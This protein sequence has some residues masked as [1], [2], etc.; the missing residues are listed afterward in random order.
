[1]A[2]LKA[3]FKL[4]DGYSTTIDKINRK[5]YVVTEKIIKAS[6]GTDNFNKKLKSTGASASIANN[7]LKKLV[8]TFLSLA[9]VK[10]GMDIADEFTNTNA[11]LNLIND[12]LQTQ[13]ELQDKIFQ[14]AD[15]AK[16]AYGD[17]ANAVARLQLL[18]GDAFLSNDET[19]AFTELLQKAFKVSGTDASEQSAALLQLSQ[20][21]ASGRLQG[22]EFVSISENAP[23]ILEA[24]SRYTGKSRGE[25]KELS[26]DGAITADII[27]NSMFAMAD[28]INEKFETLPMTFGDIWNKI[29]NGG[30]KAFRPLMEA[31]SNIINSDGFNKMLNWIFTGIGITSSAINGL[32]NLIIGNW[33][34][35]EPILI[36]IGAFLLYQLIGYLTAA[37]P[38]L[39]THAAMWIMMNMPIIRVIAMIAGVIFILQQMGVTFEDIFGFVGGVVGIFTGHFYNSFVYMWNMVASFINFFG[40]VFNN[41]VASVQALFYD[42][43]VNVLGYIENMAKGIED[44]LNKIPGVE[45]NITSGI[46][47]LKNKLAAKSAN[48]KSEAGL[49][50]YV[51]SKEFMDYSQAYTKGSNIGKNVYGD[52]SGAISDLTDKLTGTG[53]TFDLSNFGTSSN[54]LT[55]EG[56]GKNKKL[57]VDMDD[58]DLKYLRDIAER[59]YVNK[60]STA[61]LAPNIQVTF[62][63]VYEEADAGKVAGRIKKILQEEI[64]IAAEGV[65]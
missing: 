59:E 18:A 43:A 55:V 3:M 11:R 4:F 41:P 61:T 20:A 26:S 22:D 27:K 1:M 21:M 29:K 65:Y 5:T 28:D 52:I 53:S 9:V 42:L 6:Q 30:L 62:G 17:M 15:R 56:K 13:L 14:A 48:I 60:F 49:V 51:K 58:E 33:G 54:P 25:L 23:L 44:L 12:G 8:G 47:G 34:V 10:K 40:N 39:A 31:T 63:D 24:I 64:A 16:G 50:E 19:I 38:L 35:I 36:A 37:I 2:T 32:V 57:D 45:V 7:S 46:A